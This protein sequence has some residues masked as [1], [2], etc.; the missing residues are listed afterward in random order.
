MNIHSCQLS[1]K[2]EGES[3]W[4]LETDRYACERFSA[5]SE[6]FGVRG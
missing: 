4:R 1:G 6:A 2:I 3:T 5:A